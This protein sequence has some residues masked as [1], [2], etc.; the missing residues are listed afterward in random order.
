MRQ[1]FLHYVLNKMGKIGMNQTIFSHSPCN[2]TYLGVAGAKMPCFRVSPNVFNCFLIVF[3]VGL[4]YN[5]GFEIPDKF[6]IG[7]AL[8]YNEY[9]RDLNLKY[10]SRIDFLLFKRQLHHFE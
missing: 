2:Q 4:C 3:N 10:L 5:C 6:V 7:Y 9:F 8:D 1:S